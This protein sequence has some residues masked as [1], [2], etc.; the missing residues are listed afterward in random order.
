ML[1][2]YSETNS[3]LAVITKKENHDIV[4]GGGAP[5]FLVENNQRLEELSMLIARITLGMVHDLGNNIKII[6]K[7]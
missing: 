2:N 4:F 1:K 5:I 7:H 3:I 6:V